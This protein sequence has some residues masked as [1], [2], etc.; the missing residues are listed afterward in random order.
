MMSAEERVKFLLRAAR[1]VEEEG[2]GRVANLLRRMA[3][4]VL[5]TA[6]PVPELV[7]GRSEG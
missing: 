7:V 6:R 5:Q 1:R 2:D 4:E 3:H